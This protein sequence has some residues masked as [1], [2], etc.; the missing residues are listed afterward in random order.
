MPRGFKPLPSP[1]SAARRSFPRIRWPR[2]AWPGP[3]PSGAWLG[4]RGAAGSL[5]RVAAAAVYGGVLLALTAGAAVNGRA[6]LD[7][8]LERV[9]VSG[10]SA[11]TPLQVLD[12]A[13]LKAGLPMREVDPIEITRRLAAHPRVAAADVR[14][15]FPGSAWIDV[16]ERVPA[17]RVQAGAGEAVLDASGRV[18]EAGPA[19]PPL[20]LPLVLRRR[21]PLAV[22]ESV[23]DPELLRAREF[24]RLAAA[25]GWP[26]GAFEAVDASRPF[27]IAATLETGQRALFSTRGAAAELAALRAVLGAVLDVLPPR[28]ARSG[29]VDARAAGQFPGRIA[30]QP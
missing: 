23:D 25:A 19:P 22:G 7:G 4:L 30:V 5:A 3:R 20:R 26:A 1:P 8:P 28:A 10:N 15:V 29:V 17:M 11:L 6:L 2:L 16:R 18:I 21:A 12:A 24:L 14:R 13:G 27:M 9:R